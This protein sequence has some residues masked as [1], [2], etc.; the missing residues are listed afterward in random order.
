MSDDSFQA[1]FTA[2]MA[3]R[4]RAY[5]P[6]SR[7]FVGAAILTDDGQIFSGCNVENAAYPQGQCAEAN[8]IGVMVSNGATRIAEIVVIG[9]EEEDGMLC[10]PCGGCRQ[11]LREFAGA[12]MPVHICGPEGLRITMT[13]ED[14]LPLSFGP[15]NLADPTSGRSGP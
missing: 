11:R 1:L 6:Y 2:A 7:F 15:D 5:A 4:E 8:A 12:D 9:G 13:L 10:S 3:V 14:L